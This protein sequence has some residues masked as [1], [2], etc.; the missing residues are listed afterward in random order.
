MCIRQKIHRVNEEFGSFPLR[1]TFSLLD[2]T[3][4]HLERFQRGF[5]HGR[6][7]NTAAVEK[8]LVLF[9]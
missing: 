8:G 7:R 3:Q 9:Q 2:K 5:R 6:R 1:Y 4:N